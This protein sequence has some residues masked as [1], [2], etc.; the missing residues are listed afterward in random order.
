MSLEHF[1]EAADDLRANLPARWAQEVPGSELSILCDVLG[2]LLDELATA[3]ESVHADQALSTAG[4]PALLTEWAYIYRADNEQL[5]P[6]VDALRAYL[7]ARAAEDGTI[8]S[9]ENTLLSLLVTADNPG[10]PGTVGLRF[11]ADGSGLDFPAD[12]SGLTFPSGG[13]LAIVDH[14]SDYF[15]EVRVLNTLIFDR[16]AF[17]RAVA[18]FTPAHYFP[19]TITETS[20]P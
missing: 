15:L 5:P 7:Q 17:A 6:T 9:L 14:P 13:W 11:P 16:A 1:T 3:V 12:G 8:D 4:A 2:E 18:R 10:F 19:S 20:S